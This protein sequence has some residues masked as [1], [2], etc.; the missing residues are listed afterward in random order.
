VYL[1]FWRFRR[2]LVGKAD[3]QFE[4]PTFP[5]GLVFAGDAAVPLL[6]I[7]HAIRAA[8]RLREEAE[9]VIA[10]PLPSADTL[11]GRYMG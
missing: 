7:H 9:R 3:F 8:H 1:T 2:V 5:D 10:S 6:E 11:E 4:Q